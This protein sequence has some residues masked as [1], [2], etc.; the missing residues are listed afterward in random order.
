MKHP[1]SAPGKAILFGEHAVVYGRPAIA[2]PLTQIRAYANVKN[3]DKPLT[4]IAKDIDRPPLHW[5]DI[6]LA[7]TDPI[8]RMTANVCGLLRASKI[9]GEIC[10]RSTYPD[11]ARFGQRSSRFGRSRSRARGALVGCELSQDDANT[12]V[13]EVEKLHHGTPSGIDNSVVVYEKPVYF[14]KDR[15]IEF[16]HIHHPMHLVLADTGIPALTRETVADV[17]DLFNQQRPQTAAVFDAIGSIAEGARD[18]IEN[19]NQAR[20]GEL[21][22]ENHKL[23]QALNVSSTALDGLVSAALKAG[24]CGAKLSGGGRGGFIIALV[25]E[26]ASPSVRGGLLAAGAKQVYATALGGEMA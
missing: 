11:S 25:E 5:R 3:T 14:V 10:L 4:V 2:V 23:L 7:S 16:V 18:L 8:E 24:A 6:D 21:M 20:L 26:G 12:L 17:R 19:G 13:Y 9:E 1:I 15:R 22:T